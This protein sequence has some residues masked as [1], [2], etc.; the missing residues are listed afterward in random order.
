DGDSVARGEFIQVQIQLARRTEG[1]GNP[2]EWVDV[3][4]LPELKAREQALLAA[5][6]GQWAKPIAKLVDSFQFRKGFIEHV[7]LA[8]NQ[9]LLHA[10]QLFD[11]APIQRVRLHGT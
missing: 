7:T 5:H 1:G 2:A 9:F 3:A 6:G 10:E 8:G 4:R 11:L